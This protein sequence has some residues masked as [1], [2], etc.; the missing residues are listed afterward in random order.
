MSSHEILTLTLLVG[1]FALI[2]L[3]GIRRTSQHALGRLTSRLYL[4]AEGGVGALLCSLSLVSTIIGGSATLGIDTLVAKNGAAAFWWL[5]V[6]AIGLWLHAFWVVPRIR[7]MRAVTLPEVVQTYAGPLGLKWS[8]IIIALSWVAITAAQF[9]ALHKVLVSILPETVSQFCYWLAVITI[10]W[11]VAQGGQ[12]SVIRTDAVQ[13]VFL[14]LGFTAATLWVV[15]S[16][17]AQVRTMDWVPFNEHFGALDWLQLFFLVGIT[18]AVGPDMFSRTFSAKN[19]TTAKKAAQV[20]SPILV[21]FS[22]CIVLLCLL[23]P[24]FEQSIASWVTPASPLPVVIKMLMILGLVSALAGSADTVLLSAS[25]IVARDIV[26]NKSVALIRWLV[27]AF[28]F[29]A[30][31]M[32][33]MDK[34]IIGLLLKGYSFFV[35]GVAIPLLVSLIL[36]HQAPNRRLWLI[37][38]LLGGA[39]GVLSVV[40]SLSYLTYIGMAFGAL[41]AFLAWQV[42]P[43]SVAERKAYAENFQT[44]SAL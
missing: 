15:Q 9:V 2:T 8:A 26:G 13:A 7:Q 30:A 24:G 18:Y 40:L 4:T 16:S 10:L 38:S 3:W 21:F 19:A 37:G 1:Y 31:M 22:I 35:P 36:P 32:I 41:G 14:L 42:G 20:A 6:G 44:S 23:S 29:V 25:G 5:G 28:G 39:F 12:R 34:N 27:V 33:Y 43:S 11:H 17:S